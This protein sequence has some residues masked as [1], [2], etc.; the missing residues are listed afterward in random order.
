MRINVRS[1]RTASAPVCSRT[2]AA[3][4]QCSVRGS[5]CES[6]TV[7]VGLHC[8]CNVPGCTLYY[9][10]EAWIHGP[11]LYR[12]QCQ[13]RLRRSE[14]RRVGKECGAGGALGRYKDY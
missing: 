1:F 9:S 5:L 6:N 2:V 11:Y 7:S 3:P 4:L 8:L 12:Y 14:E 13:G 10:Q